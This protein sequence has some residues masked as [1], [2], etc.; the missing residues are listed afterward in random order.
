MRNNVSVH[1]AIVKKF[2]FACHQSCYP[3]LRD[4]RINNGH[5]TA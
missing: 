2:N 4:L 3:P 1:I 5:E